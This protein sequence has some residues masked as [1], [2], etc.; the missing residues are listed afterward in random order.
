MIFKKK[1]KKRRWPKVV[2][3]LLLVGAAGIGFT[4]WPFL[5]YP[6]EELDIP[7]LQA[8]APEASTLAMAGIAE[9]D[10]TPAIGIPK[11]GYS[12]WAREA[13]GFRTRLKARAFYLHG[14]DQT[15]LALVQLDLGSGSLALHHRVAELI[16][17]ETDVPA[18]ALTLLSTHTHSGPGQYLGSNFYN[19]F[20]SNKPGFDPK[21]FDFLSH[22]I[23][24]AVIS[25]YRSRR[26]A[27]F[28]MGQR[29][30]F[31]FT[32][33]RSIG[34]WARN[35]D[36]DEEQITDDMPWRAVNP[37]M[38]MLR[39]DL[40]TAEGDFQ[41]AGALTA[42]SIHGTAIPAFTRPYHAD[43]WAWLARDLEQGVAAAYDT[44]FKIRHGA[45]EATHGDNTPAWEPGNRGDREARRMGQGLATEALELF[46][47][48]DD[49]LTDQLTTAVASRQTDLLA[50]SDEQ[51]HG[52]CQRAIVGA[53]TVAGANGDEV[54]PISYI[55]WIQEGWPRKVFTDGCQG[56]KHWMLSKLQLLMP[57]DA[58][59]HQ[60]LF[61]VVRIN[62]L[63]L[64][65]LPW[66]VTLEAGNRIRDNV[67]KVLPQG[68]WTVE[69][70]STA[71]GYLGYATTAAEYGAQYYEGGHTLYGPDTTAFL[72]AFSQQLA[73][74]LFTSGDI[75]D[76]PSSTRFALLKKQY[77][78]EDESAEL[79]REIIAEPVFHAATE[80]KEAYWS[81]R[82]RG[83]PP[84]ALALHE[85]L[86]RI[87]VEEAAGWEP[88]TRNG[89]PVDDQGTD[90]QLKLLENEGT[91]AIYEVRWYRPGVATDRPLRFHIA[92]RG[93]TGPLTSP[94]F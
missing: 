43:V 3:L 73:G 44:P 20:G 54:F 76:L 45:F 65:P 48:L 56:V 74:D 9:R 51:R 5:S 8:R 81:F 27:R 11:F 35:H 36:L 72:A 31:G 90:M 60:V 41:P 52:L 4:A 94:A 12:A 1:E 26:P 21:L 19:V 92:E 14:P 85:P 37:R 18:H 7:L 40:Q 13:D 77:W 58:M 15:P 17:A 68:D 64:V 87:E 28:A 57:A 34:A 42:F 10:I 93:D 55:P 50:L 46:R 69:I 78:P 62:D 67:R 32:R 47:S 24:D 80:D 38:T 6:V 23:A 16:A 82:Y 79:Q 49:R 91:A 53:A 39:I 71:N 29:E 66:E 88:F 63:V 33:N 89:H 86:L 70:S 61:Q 75:R 84:A 25:A 83:L 22:Q 2:A 59:P 30:V